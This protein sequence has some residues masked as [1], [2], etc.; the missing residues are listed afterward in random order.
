MQKREVIMDD[1]KKLYKDYTVTISTYLYCKHTYNKLQTFGAY[2]D[3]VVAN[4]QMHERENELNKQ[5]KN[6]SCE[7][8][9]AIAHIK[10]LKK[11]EIPSFEHNAEFDNVIK[12]RDKRYHDASK[13]I[14]TI[15]KAKRNKDLS[16]GYANIIINY[17]DELGGVELM[18]KNG[19]SFPPQTY[20][21]LPDFRHFSIKEIK[22]LQGEF[23]KV[24]LEK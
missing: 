19:E 18:V 9:N 1:L 22:Q 21:S 14:S 11:L 8:K 23:E 15:Y 13:L 12:I 17:V 7:A 16:I 10:E 20:K 5:L 2:C 4:E 3:M 6:V 24:E